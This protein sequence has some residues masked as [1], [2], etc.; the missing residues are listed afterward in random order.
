M[1]TVLSASCICGYS[2]TAST[3][4]SRREHGK[5]FMYP[6]LCAGCSEVVSVDL[7]AVQQLCPK[8]G[9][10]AVTRYGVAIKEMPYGWW[11]R[12][13]ARI[14]GAQRRHDEQ[15]K[16]LM[17]SAAENSYCY[18]HHTTYG[19]STGPSVCPKCGQQGL[20]FQQTAL[21]D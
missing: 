17:S 3:A 1:G 5:V 2:A 6:H 19:I 16:K 18:R 9:S 4:S 11:P 12:L 20:H 8:C 15:T 14:T 13:V 7:L 10:S 21:F